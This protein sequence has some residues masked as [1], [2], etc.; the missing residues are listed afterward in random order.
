MFQK[1]ISQLKEAM[2]ESEYKNTTLN[3][4]TEVQQ[5]Q[6]ALKTQVRPTVVSKTNSTCIATDKVLHIF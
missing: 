4:E 1:Q 6:Q 5:R 3:A 2:N